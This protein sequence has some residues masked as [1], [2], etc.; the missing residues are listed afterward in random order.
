MAIQ[1]FCEPDELAWLHERAQQHLRIVEV[2]CWKGRS[3]AALAAGCP[4]NV[5]TVDTFEGS[6]SEL[7]GAHAE[8][9]EGLVQAEA[10]L[11]LYR[12]AN[13]S[14]IKA[15]SLAASRTFAD[16]CVDMVYLDGDHTREAMLVDLIA[17]RP[18]CLRLLCGHDVDWEGVYSALAVYGI[19]WER[20]PGSIWFMEVRGG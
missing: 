6:P 15:S 5:W 8:A 20:G 13:L 3:A 7:D 17:W 10:E 12:Y 2:G 16:G 11:N 1:G 9:A 14:I 4:G 19:P 18:K